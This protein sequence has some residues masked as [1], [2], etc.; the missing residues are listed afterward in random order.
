[1]VQYVNH[2]E[3]KQQQRNGDV[4]ISRN[5]ITKKYAS[6]NSK[7][8]KEQTCNVSNG[9]QNTKR[10]SQIFEDGRKKWF[11]TIW[12][13]LSLLYPENNFFLLMAE[14][15]KSNLMVDTFQSL[16]LKSRESNE[17]KLL[18]MISELSKQQK[19]QQKLLLELNSRFKTS[20]YVPVNNS[21][22]TSNPFLYAKQQVSL[23]H[24]GQG[25]PSAHLMVNYCLY[26]SYVYFKVIIAYA[27]DFCILTWIRAVLISVIHQK[28]II[29]WKVHRR[30]FR[31]P[32][33]KNFVHT[34]PIPDWTRIPGRLE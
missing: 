27:Y 12:T 11:T 30:L 31:L 15:L 19:Q 5:P 13:P 17:E 28:C 25:Q 10:N 33:Q 2:K 9:N 7:I 23:P 24:E 32:I 29:I 16:S 1:M 22:E 8:E 3:R 20:L 14:I 6:R 4:Q 21:S 34:S 26:Y 18:E